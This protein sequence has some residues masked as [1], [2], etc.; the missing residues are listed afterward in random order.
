MLIIQNHKQKGRLEI[1]CQTS[2]KVFSIIPLEKTKIHVN[3]GLKICC[4]KSWVVWDQRSRF[5]IVKINHEYVYIFTC[6][7][8]SKLVFWE[9][10][11]VLARV[12]HVTKHNT[13][14][15]NNP[16]L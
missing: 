15:C 9:N 4:V 1:I 7:L 8:V 6:T 12:L 14:A 2:R 3:K 13:K 11:N 5:Y 10:L 16:D